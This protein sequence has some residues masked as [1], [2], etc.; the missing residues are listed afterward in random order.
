[1]A[2]GKNNTQRIE[3]LESQA[4]SLSARLDV[5]DTLINAIN[6]LLKKCADASEGHGSKITVIEQHLHFVDLRGTVAIIAS[7]REDL[8]S[9]K[10]DI[11]NFQSWKGEQKKEKEEAIRRWWSFGPNITA[12]LIGGFITLVGILISVGLTFFINRTK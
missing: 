12:A 10:K 11:E 5:Y 3:T 4:A 8:I 6:E 7:M 2:G 1:M 9:I